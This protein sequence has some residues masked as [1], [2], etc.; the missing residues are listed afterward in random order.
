M[1][2]REFPDRWFKPHPAPAAECWWTGPVSCGVCL[3][4]WVA[5]VEIEPGADHPIVP[6][7]CP[8]CG[9]FSGNPS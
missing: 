7:E 1:S 6:L 8:E 3:H 9:H 4:D 2:I 5:V